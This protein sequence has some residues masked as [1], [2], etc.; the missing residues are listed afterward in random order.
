[1]KNLVWYLLVGTRGGETRARILDVLKHR[2]MNMHQL[3]LAL[4]LD[5]KTIQHHVRILF[6]NNFIT[7]INKDKYGGMYFVSEEME[8]LWNDFQSI[9][10]NFGKK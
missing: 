5:Y 3:A 6:D 1:M 9:W 7:A 4:E 2:P 10:N 8:K